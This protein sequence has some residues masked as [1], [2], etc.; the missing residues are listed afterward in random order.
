MTDE[1]TAADVTEIDDQK[2]ADDLT[3]M[4]KRLDALIAPLPK[5]APLRHLVDDVAEPLGV[6]IGWFVGGLYPP[7]NEAPPQ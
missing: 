5:D 2:W 4:L 3:D 1:M 6:L 7:P